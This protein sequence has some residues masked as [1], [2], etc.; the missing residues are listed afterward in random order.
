MY[1]ILF[2]QTVLL[3]IVFIQVSQCSSGCFLSVDH[4][5]DASGRKFH[6]KTPEN[7]YLAGKN[8]GF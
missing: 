3:M 2:I 5:N 4:N 6:I 7:E 1:Q 8:L